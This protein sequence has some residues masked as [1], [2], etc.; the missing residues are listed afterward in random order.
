MTHAELL[1]D[2]GIL[3]VTANSPLKK[4]N[5]ENFASEIAPL[6]ASRGKLT[7]VMI[8]AQTFPGW[9]N[10]DAFVSHLKFVAEHHRHI[11]RVAVVSDSAL[12]KIVPRIAGLF[13]QA[14]LRQFG[15]QDENL[16]L[17]WLEAGK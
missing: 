7:G 17:A 11:E 4:A 1:G 5:F 6:I 13:V 16:A 3:V 12:L 2:H 15:S 9:E 14:K 10:I 8:R